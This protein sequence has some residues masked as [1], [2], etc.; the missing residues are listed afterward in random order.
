MCTFV[1]KIFQ[2]LYNYHISIQVHFEIANFKNFAT[3]ANIW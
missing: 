2:Y 1:V 3:G